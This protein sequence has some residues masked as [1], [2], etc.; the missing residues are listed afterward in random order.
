[1]ETAA[2]RRGDLAVFN[3]KDGAA[4]FVDWME[5]LEPMTP[6]EINVMPETELDRLKRQ[7]PQT[8]DFESDTLEGK[9]G[10]GVLI[11]DPRL[12]RAPE[13]VVQYRSSWARSCI[14]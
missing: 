5:L 1:M 10:R 12:G 4:L 7:E 6:D 8:K 2:H 3:H 11:D 13:S 9:A 14:V